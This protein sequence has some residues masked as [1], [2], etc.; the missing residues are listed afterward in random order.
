MAWLRG[1]WTAAAG[2]LGVGL[3]VLVP[4]R[5]AV[6]NAD[7]AGAAAA[8]AACRARLCADGA[9][10]G[11]CGRPGAP[12][13]CTACDRRRPAWA[14]IVVLGGYGDELRTAVLRA[15]RPAGDR[16]AAALARLLVDRHR[17][18]LAAWSIDA[19]VPVPMHWVRRLVRG[20]NLAD[21]IAR[22]VAG[23]LG[24]PCRRLLARPR[25]TT[26]QN[27][28]PPAA[29]HGNVR[30]AFR[31]RAALAGRR[32]LIVDDVTTTGATL[33]AC[34]EAAVSAG[35]AAVYAAAVARADGGAS[36]DA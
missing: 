4:P 11:A 6:C 24:V 15:K 14:G 9:R 25:A 31:A 2:W 3:D 32:I 19:V 23:A 21:E 1:A 7:L 36:A 17:D 18:T 12:G 29:R 5:C 26:M 35:A 27:R 20:T 34:A 33:A 13:G 8:C 22:G 16:V 28:L 10:C 30:G